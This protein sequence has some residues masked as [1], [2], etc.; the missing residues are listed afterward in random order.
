[1]P[2][3]VRAKCI[4]F[5]VTDEMWTDIHKTAKELNITMRAYIWRLIVPDLL[6][7]KELREEENA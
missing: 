3:R 1:M 4:R 6:N 5:E 2:K 7:R